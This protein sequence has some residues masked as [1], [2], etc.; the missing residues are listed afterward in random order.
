MT[1]STPI[2]ELT[3]PVMAMAIAWGACMIVST[4]PK[5]IAPA[6]IKVIGA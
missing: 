5:A 6:R 3:R 4:R 1:R 2:L